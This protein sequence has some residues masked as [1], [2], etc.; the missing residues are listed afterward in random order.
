MPSGVRLQRIANRF[1]EEL[2]EMLLREINDPR[3]KLIYVTD[4]K[5]DKELAYADV[6]V[7]AVEGVSRSKDVLAG[8]ESASGFI[9]RTLASRI[10]LRA[11]PRLRFHWDMTPE[12][13]D[14]IEKVL[15]ELRNKK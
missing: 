15:A 9:R 2:S 6:Y 5:V 4:V 7:S 1:R 3:L 12:K 13:A 14:H 11:F 10:E 8:L